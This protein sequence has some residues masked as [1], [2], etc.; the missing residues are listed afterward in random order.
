M[1]RLAKE[2]DELSVVDDQF[3]APTSAKAIAREILRYI[4]KDD[5]PYGLFHLESSPGVT[6]YEFS[7]RIFARA[8]HFNVVDHSP[9]LTPISSLSFPTP[10]K[11][12]QNSKLSAGGKSI[13]P[14]QHWQADLDDLLL[15]IKDQK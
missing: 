3:G 12:P 9:A 2:R 4:L 14:V 7:Q 8:T 5:S 15:R 1:L 10:V 13:F 11:R 6:W